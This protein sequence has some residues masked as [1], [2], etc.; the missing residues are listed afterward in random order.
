MKNILLSTMIMRVLYCWLNGSDIT[1]VE[2]R[3][4]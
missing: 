4:L 1:H 2:Q 3:F